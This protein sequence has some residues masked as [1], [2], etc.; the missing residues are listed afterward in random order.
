MLHKQNVSSFKAPP[1]VTVSKF[2]WTFKTRIPP[3]IRIPLSLASCSSTLW[4][5]KT[6]RSASWTMFFLWLCP[7]AMAFS[8]PHS[9]ALR[10]APGLGPV[11]LALSP[12]VT[13]SWRTVGCQSGSLPCLLEDIGNQE[14]SGQSQLVSHKVVLLGQNPL[15]EASF[16]HKLQA[17][18]SKMC[19]QATETLPHRKGIR[20][21][22]GWAEQNWGHSM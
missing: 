7:A 3:K 10:Q 12:A 1:Y 2:T 21:C 8:P 11:L 4:P 20:K 9:L 15:L 19:L 17:I 22:K 5:R 14:L 16:W 18:C 6:A 13:L